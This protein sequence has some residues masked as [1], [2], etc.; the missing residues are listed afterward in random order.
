MVSNNHFVGVPPAR[1]R[2]TPEF[3]PGGIRRGLV[4]GRRAAAPATLLAAPPCGGAPW[5]PDGPVAHGSSC[6]CRRRRP[7]AALLAAAGTAEAAATAAALGLVD[8]GGR[9]AQRGADLVDLHLDDGAL[10]ALLGL[11]RARLQAAGDDHAGAA[12]QGLGDVLGCV[13]PRSSA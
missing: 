8:L 7:A 1:A 6:C 4:V 11:V 5:A 2:G 9:V 12:L 13:A 10:L 3:R